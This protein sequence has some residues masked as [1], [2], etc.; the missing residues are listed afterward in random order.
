[1][2]EGLNTKPSK[3]L[4]NQ[5]LMKDLPMAKLAG[6]LLLVST[7]E[8]LHLQQLFPRACRRGENL[9]KMAEGFQHPTAY[10][11]SGAKHI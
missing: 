7:Q 2:E 11:R 4:D 3:I 5:H 6:M 9:T 1:M 8:E 10:L